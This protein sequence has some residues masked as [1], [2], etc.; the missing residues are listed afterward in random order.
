MTAISEFWPETGLAW[1]EPSRRPHGCSRRGRGRVFLLRALLPHG[2]QCDKSLLPSCLRDQGSPIRL[3]PT[4]RL[5]GTP[6]HLTVAARAFAATFHC[7]LHGTPFHLQR[8][9]HLSG[10]PVSCMARPLLPRL[11][12]ND[13]IY[14]FEPPKLGAARLLNGLCGIGVQHWAPH[15][16]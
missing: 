10:G 9:P 1:P 4:V 3:R 8:T 2:Q 6:L 13:S 16:G 11:A 5:Q 15:C 12:Q 14:A 7:R